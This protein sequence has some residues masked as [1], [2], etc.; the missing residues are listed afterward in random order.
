MASPTVW[1]VDVKPDWI[2]S[3]FL[4]PSEGVPTTDRA[5][6]TKD[7]SGDACGSARNGGNCSRTLHTLPANAFRNNVTVVSIV[8]P[9]GVVEI[10]SHAFANCP[11]LTTVTLPTTVQKIGANAF[12]NSGIASLSLPDSVDSIGASAFKSCHHLTELAIPPKVKRLS[13]STMAYCTGLRM[14]SFPEGLEEIECNA[15]R[16]C[17]GLEEIVIPNSVTRIEINAFSYCTSVKNVVVASASCNGRPFFGGGSAAL[18]QI[19][20]DAVIT[21]KI[22]TSFKIAG[23]I[24]FLDSV[25][26]KKRVVVFPTFLKTMAG[27]SIQAPPDTVIEAGDSAAKAFATV[28]NVQTL[29]LQ[30]AADALDVFP[31]EIF[32]ADGIILYRPSIRVKVVAT[33]ATNSSLASRGRLFGRYSRTKQQQHAQPATTPAA[34]LSATSNTT[35]LTVELARDVLVPWVLLQLFGRAPHVDVAPAIQYACAKIGK[36]LRVDAQLS[37]MSIHC[38]TTA[39]NGLVGT[40]GDAS[41]AAGRERALPSTAASSPSAGRR[42]YTDARGGG[43]GNAFASSNFGD[44]ETGGAGM[45][46][47]PATLLDAGVMDGAIIYVSIEPREPA[48]A[49]KCVVM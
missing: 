19:S 47:G 43:D 24:A 27:D 45:Q 37:V 2:T 10:G 32:V 42:A 9:N 46:Q 31:E 1:R 35:A 7:A 36:V 22:D 40:A 4:G 13:L 34:P 18:C 11:N 25:S 6:G 30:A 48:T 20:A 39:N 15:F 49:R 5:A 17:I 14:I 26:A 23:L 38:G 29:M 28:G 33:V 44:A 3:T 16:S 41:T 21:V 8:V 12:A